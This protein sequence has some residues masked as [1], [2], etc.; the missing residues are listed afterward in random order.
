MM[1]NAIL[2]GRLFM[3][4]VALVTILLIYRIGTL[5]FQRRVGALAAL[6]LALLPAHVVW[7]QRVRPDELA[8]LLA[9]A[10]FYLA[11]KVYLSGPQRRRYL[12]GAALVTGFAVAFRFP[13]LL[14]AIPA[15]LAFLRRE[16]DA[17]AD[18]RRITA[19]LG[20]AVVCT[21]AGYL[22]GS[23]QSLSS[24]Q[25]LLAGMHIQWDYQSQPFPPAIG[26]GPGL[27]QYGW[28]MMILA[29]S[30]PVYLLAAAGAV[31][32]VRRR[33]FAIALVL[34]ALLPYLLLTSFTNWVVVRYLLPVV[35]FMVLLA[36]YAADYWLRRSPRPVL[37]GAALLTTV[38]WLLMISFSYTRMETGTNI[39]D[40]AGQWAE[41]NIAPGTPVLKVIGYHGDFSSNLLLRQANNQYVYSLKSAVDP[42]LLLK[43]LKP[44]YV[45]VG[46]QYL[47]E[48]RRL[49]P[50]YPGRRPKAFYRAL[51]AGNYELMRR[52]ERP[53]LL[54]GLNVQSLFSS[55]D[56]RVPNPT[57]YVFKRVQR[58]G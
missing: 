29:V 26:R 6:L 37:A 54:M 33:D 39:R 45:F 32:G 18:W 28:T 4:V 41:R 34:S 3:T 13:L 53:P 15:G 58:R 20:L 2:F 8:A 47:D 49:G 22:L 44:E 27:Y 5:L 12:Y 30:H 36:A 52:F 16:F 57:I 55:L 9:V 40:V 11:V 24:P 21:L 43:G 31:V 10:L 48:L 56:Y 14:F 7:A 19:P 35:P 38:P 50:R 23:P 42:A 1:G 51:T 17:G 46:S 25:H